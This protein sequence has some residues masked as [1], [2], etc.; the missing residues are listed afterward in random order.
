MC[1]YA[2]MCAYMQFGWVCQHVWCVHVSFVYECVCVCVCS[3]MVSVCVGVCV[4]VSVLVC[5]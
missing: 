4:F 5:L 3:S 1:E 2:C